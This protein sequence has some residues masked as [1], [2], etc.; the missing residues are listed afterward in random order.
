[1]MPKKYFIF[2][3]LI[4]FGF[5]NGCG[6]HEGVVQKEAKSYIY[7]TGNS[8]DAVVFIDDLAPITISEDSDNTHF[9]I[10]P[11]THTV[12]VKKSGKEVVNRRILLGSGITREISIP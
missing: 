2:I 8:L 12:V 6:L 5:C 3:T 7:F 11:G 9:E 4:L 1:M 10:S